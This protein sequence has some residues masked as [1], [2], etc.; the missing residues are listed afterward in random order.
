MERFLGVHFLLHLTF[1]DSFGTNQFAYRCFHGVRDAILFVL[2][3][4]LVVFAKGKK[5]GVYCSDVS[6]AFDQMSTFNLL[7]KL[8]RP[9]IHNKIVDVN[10]DWLVGRRGEVIVQGSSSDCFPVSN[11]NYQGTIWGPPLWNLFFSDVRLALRRCGFSEVIYADDLNA[12]R[13]FW[14]D[15]SNDFILFQLRRCQFELHD[16]GAATCV[17]YDPEKEGFHYFSK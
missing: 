10:A 1:S 15:V 11:M 2:L 16:R 17:S 13:A 7:A 12:Y 14:N 9:I 5:V 3:T 4:W 8:R 6:S